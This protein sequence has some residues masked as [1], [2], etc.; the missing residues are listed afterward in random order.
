MK[1]FMIATA[2]TLSMAAPAFAATEAE[3]SIIS[4]YLPNADISGWN[5]EQ[6]NSALAIINSGDSRGNIA[7]KL[8][9]LYGGTE[10]TPTAAEI[11]EAE[12][13]ELQKYAP[14]TDFS[15]YPQATVDAAISALNSG[16]SEGDLQ[17]R[18]DSL[19]STDTNP[20]GEA[21]TATA[22]E[23][24]LIN[25]YAP[26]VNVAALTEEQVNASLS[27]IYSNNGDADIEDRIVSY[28]EASQ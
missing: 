17:G 11:S 15:M 14:N 12:M 16:L 13:V 10:Y 24:A 23:A 21:N 3:M 9:A 26:S 22:A 5:D 4:S 7:G 27:I 18:I 2:L 20:M 6:V 28:V 8:Q 25:Q 19:F 1:R